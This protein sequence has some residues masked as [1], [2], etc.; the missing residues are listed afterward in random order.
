MNTNFVYSFENSLT[1]AFNQMLVGIIGFIPS[2]LGA[3]VLF[4]LGLIVAGWLKTLTVKFLNL[5]K[6]GG[7]FK[8]PSIKRFLQNAQITRKN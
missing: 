2:L 7:Y 4:L 6:L 5:T 3:L 8:N 1:Y